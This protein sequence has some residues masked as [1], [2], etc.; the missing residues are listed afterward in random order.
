MLN[1]FLI[2]MRQAIHQYI[3]I[4]HKNNSVLTNSSVLSVQEQ[5]GL[6]IAQHRCLL[7]IFVNILKQILAICKVKSEFQNISKCRSNDQSH[8]TSQIT[9]LDLYHKRFLVSMMLIFQR[10]P[11]IPSVQYSPGIDSRL[12]IALSWFLMRSCIM[13]G[14]LAISIVCRRISGLLSM[15]LNSGLRSINWKFR[16]WF[17]E[18][19]TRAV[20]VWLSW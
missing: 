15:W 4:M 18:Y 1:I 10:W 16:K 2:G 13:A 3:C 11:Y 7:L 20:V 8:Y 14:F 12:D 6:R 19:N 9:T 5:S 17:K